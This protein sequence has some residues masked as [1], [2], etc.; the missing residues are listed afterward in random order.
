MKVTLSHS[1]DADHDCETTVIAKLL[2]GSE[3]HVHLNFTAGECAT[4]HEIKT[5]I[6][7]GPG[8]MHTGLARITVA[9]CDL[10]DAF[11]TGEAQVTE[12]EI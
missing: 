8:V 7:K 10:I 1:F 2:D 11:F 4:L 12:I 9:A 5:T 3:V 6:A